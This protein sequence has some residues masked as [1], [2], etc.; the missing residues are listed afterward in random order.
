MYPTINKTSKDDYLI[1]EMISKKSYK[2][3][4]ST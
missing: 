2:K 4:A 3:F 1:A